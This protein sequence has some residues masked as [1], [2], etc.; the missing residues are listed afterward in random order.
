M[1]SRTVPQR[2][3]FTTIYTEVEGLRASNGGFEI[4][5]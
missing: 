2:V 5:Y 4:G 1:I 3:S